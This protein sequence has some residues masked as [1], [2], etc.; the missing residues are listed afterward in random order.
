MKTTTLPV[1]SPQWL[2]IDAAGQSLGRVAVKAAHCLR[3]KH[4][5]S[6]SPHQACGDHVVVINV[7]QLAIPP[8]KIY[9]KT[10]YRYTGYM[11]NMKETSLPQLMEKHP[12]RVI[13][14]AVKGML[15]NNRLRTKILKR[16]HVYADD[17]HPY[18]AQQP[19]SILVA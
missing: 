18:E 12:E 8:K 4:K 16:L 9:R 19:T 3:G 13:E 15:T 10:Y 5:A 2:L 1:G 14:I 17:K 7:K 11:G 6:F